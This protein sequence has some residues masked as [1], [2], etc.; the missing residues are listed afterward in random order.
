MQIV[1]VDCLKIRSIRRAEDLICDLGPGDLCDCGRH[2]FLDP[3]RR[4]PCCILPLFL[5]LCVGVCCDLG[6]NDVVRRDGC[7]GLR[8]R[9]LLDVA[10]PYGGLIDILSSCLALRCRGRPSHRPTIH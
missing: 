7:L 1:L 6:R 9:L 10:L 2:G 3:Y 5:V 8:N 4:E